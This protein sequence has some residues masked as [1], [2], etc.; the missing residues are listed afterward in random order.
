MND[1]PLTSFLEQTINIREQ[2]RYG[3]RG[4]ELLRG[5]QIQPH[6]GPVRQNAYGQGRV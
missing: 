4:A 1:K 6:E 3:I 5:Q 2:T